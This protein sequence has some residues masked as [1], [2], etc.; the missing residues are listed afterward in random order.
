MVATVHTRGLRGHA[1]YRYLGE[2]RRGWSEG[3]RVE[4]EGI[5]GKDGRRGVWERMAG[6]EGERGGRERRGIVGWGRRAGTEGQ[7][8]GGSNHFNLQ[9]LEVAGVYLYFFYFIIFFQKNVLQNKLNLPSII[10]QG[11]GAENSCSFTF[12]FTLTLTLLTWLYLTQHMSS[13]AHCN[14]K[15]GIL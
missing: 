15:N 8:R 14:I 10:M 7:R 5:A 2:G 9:N 13:C 3:R 11:Q 12:M 1:R 4:R 6:E